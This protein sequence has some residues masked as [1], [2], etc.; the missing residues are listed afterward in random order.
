MIV[1]KKYAYAREPLTVR[2]CPVCHFSCDPDVTYRLRFKQLKVN[3][4]DESGENVNLYA[5]PKC[6]TIG[7]DIYEVEY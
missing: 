1:R 2:E 4:K 3:C 7:I 6:G 5:C